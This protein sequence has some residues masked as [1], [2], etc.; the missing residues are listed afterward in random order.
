MEITPQEIRQQ[1]F[2]VKLRGFDPEEVDTFLDMVADEFEILIQAGK[3]TR[4]KVKSLEE[5]SKALEMEVK[6]LR[7]ALG[8]AER[9]KAQAL[10]AAQRDKEQAL[11]AA[12][13]AMAQTKEALRTETGEARAL[14]AREAQAIVEVAR[15]ERAKAQEEVEA[16]AEQRREMVEQVRN[17]L[18]SQLRLLEMEGAEAPSTAPPKAR[19]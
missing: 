16:L 13:K 4:Q 3:A 10:G 8:A 19:G 12:E 14:A 6:R 17:L 1:R 5:K 18:E 9:S 11:W 2:H 15:Y 7:E